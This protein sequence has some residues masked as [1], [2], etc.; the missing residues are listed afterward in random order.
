MPAAGNSKDFW[1]ARAR[2]DAFHFVDDRL[3]YRDPDEGLFWQRG[4]EDLDAI[5]ARLGARLDGSEQVVEIGCGLG[6]LTR[7]LAARARDVR[8]TCARS[9]FPRRCSP[10]PASTTR[11]WTT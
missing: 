1:D 2:E 5:F 4:E 6:R 11:T 10:A 8:A 7:P 3:T 9:T